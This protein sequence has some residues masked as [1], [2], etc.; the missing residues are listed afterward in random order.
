M[1]NTCMIQLAEIEDVLSSEDMERLYEYVEIEEIE[2][3]E[4]TA[5]A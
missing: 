2:V 3:E 4:A 5:S 1:G